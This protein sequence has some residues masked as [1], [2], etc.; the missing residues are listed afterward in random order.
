[1]EKLWKESLNSDDQQL[2]HFQQMNNYLY[3]VGNPGPGAG[4]QMSQGN[5]MSMCSCDF[6]SSCV[7]YY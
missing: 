1:M 3:D 5:D 7:L 4:T 2:H 6:D